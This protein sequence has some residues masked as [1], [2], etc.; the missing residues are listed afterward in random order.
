MNLG[1]MLEGL[2]SHHPKICVYFYAHASKCI[3]SDGALAS[4]EIDIPK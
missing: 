4:Y 1:I 3:N 2:D